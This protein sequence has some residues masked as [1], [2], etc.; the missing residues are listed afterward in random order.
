M[1]FKKAIKVKLKK[2]EMNSEN[3]SIRRI[4]VFISLG[5]P[6][7]ISARF[8]NKS[9]FSFEMVTEAMYSYDFRIAA[10]KVE[11]LLKASIIGNTMLSP[12]LALRAADSA[13]N[14]ARTVR[15]CSPF[16]KI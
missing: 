16:P 6:M 8:R 13:D 5:K 12:F 11:V 2:K 14:T 15:C 10:F 3:L 4:R 9:F 7:D 1:N